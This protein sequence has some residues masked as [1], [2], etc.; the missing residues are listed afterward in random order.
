MDGLKLLLRPMSA[1]PALGEAARVSSKFTTRV[2]AIVG[3]LALAF[4]LN[5][6]LATVMGCPTS[7]T[8][9]VSGAT[10][11]EVSTAT[12]D[13]PAPGVVNSEEFF[14]YDDWEFGGKI[15]FEYDEGI[16]TIVTEDGDV[17]IGFSA[18][19]TPVGDD[20]LSGTFSVDAFGAW[21]DVMLI[22]KDGVNTTLV[23]Y[24]LGEGTGTWDSPFEPSVFTSLRN[25]A[26]VSHLSAYVRG[27]TS[28]PEPGSLALLA[29]G[30]AGVVAFGRRRKLGAG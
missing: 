16:T 14:S 28:V 18:G 7:I 6:A 22:F 5:P 15:E 25:T 17:D 4:W 30:L 3:S 2:G 24:L 20:F 27:P 19:S 23:G 9:N 13:N 1:G 21:D 12:N 8:N 11:C 10:G 29:A 26:S